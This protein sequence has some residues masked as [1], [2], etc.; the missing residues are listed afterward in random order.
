MGVIVVSTEKAWKEQL[1]R[2]KSAKTPVPHLYPLSIPDIYSLISFR[3]CFGFEIC[4]CNTFLKVD[5]DVN[6][7]LGVPEA[8]MKAGAVYKYNL[9][10]PVEKMYNLVEEMR[11]RLGRNSAKVNGY[12][13]LGDGNL[14]LNISTPQYDAMVQLMASI[15]KLMDPHG[16]L[17]PYKVLP[18]STSHS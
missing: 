10:L 5:M 4:R 12:G 1:Q 15:K 11:T 18:H 13:H 17:N 9:S 14:H 7:L 8:L 3:C 6:A 2:A 16:I